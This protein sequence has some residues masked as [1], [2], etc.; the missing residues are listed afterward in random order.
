MR[1]RRRSVPWIAAALLLRA[2]T[3]AAS[4]LLS[5]AAGARD[6]A[7]TGAT[8]AAP[9]DLMSA[10]FE[11]PAGLSLLDEPQ[12]TAGSGFI[13]GQS[14]IRTPFGY[15]GD[16]DSVGLAPNFGTA[17]ARGRW[18]F[19]VGLFGSVGSK[20]DF[21]A[22]PEH[23][24]A[25]NFY[26]ELG[27]ITIAPTVAY[28]VTP[29]LAIGIQVNPLYGTLKNRVPTPEQQLR[30]HVQGPGIQGV[31]G[32]LYTPHPDWRLGVTYKTPGKIFMNGTVGVAGKREDLRFDFYVPQQVF[33]GAAWRA[34]PRLL[35]TV[36]GQWADTSAFERARF[37]FSDTPALDFAFAP[38]S[39]DVL[40]GG[41]GIEYQAHPRLALRAGFARG[42]A[43]LEPGS[44]TPLVYD[45]SG[46]IFG[47]GFGLDLGGWTIDVTSGYGVF[48]DRKINAGEARVFPGRYSAGGPVVYSELTRRF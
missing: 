21:P 36:F 17:T 25:R 30:W 19:G 40:R 9:S 2:A 34:T 7:M 4:T 22:D 13:I 47:A 1:T 24:I 43:A 42:E 32:L 3:A 26:T 29:A 5:P 37:E 23:G 31:V 16:S 6:A 45:V 48:D 38:K 18:H 20:F 35:L 33:L 44:V 15:R 14:E 46:T 12:A 41:A 11:N 8:V 28:E 39:R 27:A 10:L